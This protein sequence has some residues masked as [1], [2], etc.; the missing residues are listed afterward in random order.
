MLPPR[1]SALLSKIRPAL[2]RARQGWRPLMIV[3]GALAGFTVAASLVRLPPGFLAAAYFGL[4]LA[5][6]WIALRRLRLDVVTILL[7]LGGFCLYLLYLTYT[8]YGE[9]NYDGPEQ[10][11]YIQYIA[12][13]RSLPPAGHCFICHHPPAYYLSAAAVYLLFQKTALGDP[14][15][16]VQLYSLLLSML[17]ILFAV[18]TVRL[19]T[20]DRRQIRLAT[21]LVVFWPYAIHN[22]VRVHND[23]MVCTLM[24]VALYFVVRWYRE[25]RSWQ[26]YTAAAITAGGILS[27]SNGVIL[28]VVLG[29]AVAAKLYRSRDRL[30]LLGRA[31]IVVAVLVAAVGANTIGKGNL[32]DDEPS[33]G[34]P[35]C[36]R[37]LGSACKMAMTEH[38]G[39]RPYNYLYFDTQSFFKEPFLIAR[40]DGSGRQFFWNHLLKSSLLGTHNEVPD[41]E[42]AY[43]L[44]RDVAA[45]LNILLFG[46][47]A[48]LLA[49]LLFLRR[50]AA[51]R[52]WLIF[53]SLGVYLAFMAA[54]RILIPWSHHTDFRHVFPVLALMATLYAG[55]VALFRERQAVME[56]VGYALAVPF[57]LLSVFYFIPKYD[58]AIRVTARIVKVEMADYAKVVREGTD[59][60][61]RTNLIIEGNHTIELKPEGR[62]TVR[63]IDITFDNNDTYEVKVFGKGGP[64]IL[65][66]GPTKKKKAK[67]LVRYQEPVDPPVERASMITIRPIAG[68]RAYSMGHILVR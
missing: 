38:I 54:F 23:T 49:A 29:V 35:F 30:R 43:E 3:G 67:G 57:L 10:L 36:A 64:R 68:D 34:G 2:R 39:N 20:E 28:A 19:L 40:H 53:T 66:I 59:W 1:V 9:R 21:A 32:L 14:I 45:G 24:V 4:F 7:I 15:R 22:S 48:Y 65:H 31:A 33:R 8:W 42:L 18:L 44:N 46:M 61:K 60:D 5:L 13:H 58:W 17:F 6:L 63:E 37:V 51:R 26:L 50:Q 27:K 55:A 41:R 56:Y 16:G 25:S 52:Y 11:K 12:E 62:P 47:T